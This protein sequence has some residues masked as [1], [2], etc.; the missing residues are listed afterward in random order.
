MFRINLLGIFFVSQQAARHVRSGGTIVNF[1]SSVLGRA[2]PSY[3]GFAAT[4][5]ETVQGS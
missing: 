4:L 3:T 2:L 5:A 1:S